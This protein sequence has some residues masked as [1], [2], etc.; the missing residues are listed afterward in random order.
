M[1]RNRFFSPFGVCAGIHTS[2]QLS[3][4]Y[5]FCPTDLREVIDCLLLWAGAP[6][7]L[8]LIEKVER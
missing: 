5:L 3:F 4:A 8:M 6:A 7:D 2:T 1:D